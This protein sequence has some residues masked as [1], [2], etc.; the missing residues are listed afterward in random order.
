MGH[1]SANPHLPYHDNKK[2]VITVFY[3]KHILNFF[4]NERKVAFV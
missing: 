3:V 4:W 1:I 2:A